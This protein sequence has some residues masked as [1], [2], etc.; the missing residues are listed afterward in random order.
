[1]SGPSPA[2]F[3]VRPQRVRRVAAAAAVVIV[4]VF[5]A[6]ATL[7]TGD[8]TGVYFRPADQV[9]M[10]LFGLMLA[11]AVLLL[12]RPRVR[13][14]VHGVAVRNVL[15]EQSFPWP[16]VREV[17]FPKD[18]SWARLELPDDEYVAIMA[19]Q[20]ADG[21]RAVQAINRLRALHRTYT[22]TTDTTG[23]QRAV[24]DGSAA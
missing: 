8:S 20:A 1:V 14:G 16:L 18:A 4:V 13:V 17:S 3:E 2:D 15:G 19:I 23:P 5:T 6:V 11:G 12:T 22:D 9:A 21:D 10:I 24:E 7:L